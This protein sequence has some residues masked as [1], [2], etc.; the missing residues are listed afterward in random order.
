MTTLLK[1]K[2]LRRNKGYSI[3]KLSEL[4]GISKSTLNDLENNKSIPRPEDLEKIARAL[5]V[6]PKELWKGD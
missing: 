2:Q 5:E 6:T 4:T 3:R 1:I